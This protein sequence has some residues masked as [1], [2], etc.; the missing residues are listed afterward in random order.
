MAACMST[1]LSFF[2]ELKVTGVII[3]NILMNVGYVM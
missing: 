2:A 1:V 3:E